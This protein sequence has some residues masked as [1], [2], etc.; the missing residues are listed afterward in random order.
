MK[1]MIW[2]EGKL[3]EEKPETTDRWTI[4][5][6]HELQIEL[7]GCTVRLKQN[8][9]ALTAARMGVGACVWEGELLLAAYLASLPQH[10]YIGAR[11]VELGSG[12]GLIG[13]LMAK[14]G[15]KVV[16]TDIKKVLPLIEDNVKLNELSVEQRRGAES[17]IAEVEE[18]E[19]G[20]EG[21]M[22]RVESLASGG[23][24]DWIVAADCC[25]IDNEGLSPSTSHFI[26]TCHG[27]CS[28]STRCLV[29]FE[30]RSNEVKGTF[31]GEARRA[32]AKVTRVPAR[33]LPKGCQVDH[34]ELYDLE[35]KRAD[36]VFE[37]IN[38]PAY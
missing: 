22:S 8:P 18:L 6:A 20:A 31:L 32:F 17:G 15:A 1:L 19:W 12:P 14:L 24:L 4:H 26:R 29:S 35:E 16:I 33:S 13:L 27:L 3:V 38:V 23:P 25:Y 11:C 7:A 36:Y 21:Y 5:S 37:E 34:I 28:A 9:H 30:L 10:R 2:E